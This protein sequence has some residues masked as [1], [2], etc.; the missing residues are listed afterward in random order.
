MKKVFLGTDN[1]LH[2][3][4]YNRSL[5]CPLD[6]I[7]SSCGAPCG[8]WCAWFDVEVY[9]YAGQGDIKTIICKGEPIAELVEE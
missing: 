3:K 5:L 8:V 6:S 7:S 2:S 9:K 4:E 1:C